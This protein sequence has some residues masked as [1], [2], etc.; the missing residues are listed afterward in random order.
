V[1]GCAVLY[2]MA[3]SQLAF[4]GPTS[5]VIF[6]AILT[7]IRLSRRAL[8][9]IC[10]RGL[11]EIIGKSANELRAGAQFIAL[12]LSARSPAKSGPPCGYGV[13]VSVAGLLTVPYLPEIVAFLVFVTALVVT[14][15]VAVVE[16]ART[17]TLGGTVAN[18]RLLASVTTTPADGA[19]PFNVT[20][21]IDEIPPFTVVGLRLRDCNAGARTVRVAVRVTP[22]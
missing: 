3:T 18:V 7:K 19:E 2:E 5:P 11:E 17:V 16:P 21:P 6:G 10:L 12:C 9:Q 4:S 13:T 14:V 15:K 8:I 20:V 1:F 22:E